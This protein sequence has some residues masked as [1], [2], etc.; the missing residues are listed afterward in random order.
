[1]DRAEAMNETT[2]GKGILH[3]CVESK[4]KGASVQYSSRDP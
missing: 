4:A 1:V 3:S 2:E